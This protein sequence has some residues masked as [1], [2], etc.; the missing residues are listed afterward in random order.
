MSTFFS[1]VW[2]NKSARYAAL[3]WGLFVTEN[4][5]LSEN[6]TYI[7]DKLG[8]NTYRS[9]Y[10]CFSTISMA[11][12][13]ISYFKYSKG[14]W[15]IG[16]KIG[17]GKRLAGLLLQGFALSLYFQSVPLIRFDRQSPQDENNNQQFQKEIFEAKDSKTGKKINKV[18]ESTQT[19]IT[20]EDLKFPQSHH[21]WSRH[22][23]LWALGL[24]GLGSALMTP[25]M[26]RVVFCTCPLLAISILSSHQD[27]RFRRG[28]GGQLTEEMEKQSSNFPGL[29]YLDGT[30]SFSKFIY[31]DMKVSNVAIAWGIAFLLNIRRGR[32]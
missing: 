20:A 10:G 32:I 6:R 11:S 23:Q 12:V 15:M 25:Y 1:K 3:G 29:R 27:S 21:T 18:S 2:Q 30:Y 9:I 19:T 16:G 28:I 4:L 5:A 13:A 14:D 8:L 7:I 17:Y 24:F 31:D 26:S 22:P